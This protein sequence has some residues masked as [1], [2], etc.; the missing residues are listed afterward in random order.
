MT[1]TRLR[2][3]AD[4]A[5]LKFSVDGAAHFDR[6]GPR[7]CCANPVARD[8][9]RRSSGIDLRKQKSPFVVGL[10][11]ACRLRFD[12]GGR[13]RGI[14]QAPRRY[15]STT[16]PEIALEVPLCARQT[17]ELTMVNSRERKKKISGMCL[18]PRRIQ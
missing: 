9:R 11:G 16:V 6:D 18:D 3:A 1:S 4:M 7:V 14:G 13:D 17:C 10:P 12:F 2:S 5:R 15:E 8:R